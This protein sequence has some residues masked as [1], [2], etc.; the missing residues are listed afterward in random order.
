MSVYNQNN[1]HSAMKHMERIHIIMPIHK[2]P[3]QIFTRAVN[4]V[5]RQSFRK[6]R[7]TIVESKESLKASRDCKEFVDELM[8][9]DSR[10][11]YKTQRGI[12]VSSARNQALDE[13]RTTLVA[14]LDGDD[15]WES[16][17]LEVMAG[18]AG[19]MPE[20]DI[21]WCKAMYQ[22]NVVSQFTGEHDVQILPF[23]EYEDIEYVHEDLYHYYFMTVPVYPSGMV[24]RRT[25]IEEVGLFD[26]T[27]NRVED[28][29][30]LMRLTEPDIEG[31]SRKCY[32]INFPLMYR[33]MSKEDT[34]MDSWI[35]AR[36]SQELLAMRYPLPNSYNQPA[37]IS[38]IDWSLILDIVAPLVQ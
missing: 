14:F 11:V 6:W 32:Y 26:E 29:D 31:V 25:A 13:E 7:L 21:F 24:V 5:L 22:N 34:K 1:R 19:A 33:E 17:Y 10:V 9:E 27:I 23:E 37:H 36:E 16:T 28:V 15:W 12:G 2:V 30:L 3:V 18:Y 8:L 4:S 20:K 35:T 38:E